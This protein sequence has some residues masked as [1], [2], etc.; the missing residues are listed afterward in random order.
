[1]RWPRRRTLLGAAVLL[2]IASPT[3]VVARDY[4]SGAITVSKPWSRATPPSAQV[5]GGYLSIANSGTEDDRLVAMRSPAARRVAVHEMKMDGSIMRMR[6][7]ED[8]LV[9]PAKSTVNLEP[10]GYHLMFVDLTRG[11]VK[12][13][14]IPVT[15]VVERAGE[16]D[17][18]FEVLALGAKPPER[19]R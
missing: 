10:G 1:M 11:L 6:A 12:G 2:I 8:G 18:V 13:A 3:G 16:I 5:G 4:G 17:V 14:G 15:L 19:G 9:I 7:L